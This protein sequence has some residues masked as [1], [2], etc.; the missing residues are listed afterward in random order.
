VVCVDQGVCYVEKEKEHL[1]CFIKLYIHVFAVPDSYLAFQLYF[2]VLFKCI[3]GHA[4]KGG[5][6]VNRASH[7]R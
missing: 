4:L 5:E 7:L 1:L 2:N 3:L 6:A